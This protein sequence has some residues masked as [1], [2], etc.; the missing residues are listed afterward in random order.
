M[1]RHLSQ[2]W[3]HV[4]PLS[5]NRATCTL[6][7][8]CSQ[9]RVSHVP[10]PG[11]WWQLPLP[12]PQSWQ[13]PGLQ[14]DNWAIADLP[15]SISWNESWQF[16]FQDGITLVTLHKLGPGFD[17]LIILSAVPHVITSLSHSDMTQCSSTSKLF[18][19]GKDAITTLLHTWYK[20]NIDIL[21]FQG[22]MGPLTLAPAGS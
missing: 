11:P 21:G 20:H 4:L 1:W 3:Q 15:T 5:T 2:P 6:V 13:N 12:P 22:P 8:D 10:C 14:M 7:A 19:G 18:T 9:W 16:C 17:T